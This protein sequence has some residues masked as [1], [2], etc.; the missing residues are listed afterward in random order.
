MAK[1]RP[2]G[3][4]KQPTGPKNPGAISCIFLLVVGFALLG[5]VLY[6]SIARP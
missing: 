1:I 6:V 4:R 2:A 5:L 3:S